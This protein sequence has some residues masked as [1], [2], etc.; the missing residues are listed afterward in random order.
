MC[1]L[2][3]HS[4]ANY[5]LQRAHQKLIDHEKT[6]KTVEVVPTSNYKDKYVHLIGQDAALEAAKKTKSNKNYGFGK[7]LLSKVI[8]EN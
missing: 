2:Y 1:T 4:N 7:D 8:I 5:C 6:R 3:L